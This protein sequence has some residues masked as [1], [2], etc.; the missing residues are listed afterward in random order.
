MIF[1]FSLDLHHNAHWLLGR[2]FERADHN[3]ESLGSSLRLAQVSQDMQGQLRII[4]LIASTE[5]RYD[6]TE[7]NLNGM[8]DFTPTRFQDWL[9]TAWWGHFTPL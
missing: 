1:S 6:F 8:V 2:P 9:R 5:G 7:A 3:L 4:A